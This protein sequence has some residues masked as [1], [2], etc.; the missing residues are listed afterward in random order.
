MKILLKRSLII[1]LAIFLL[2]ASSGCIET[3]AASPALIDEDAL[4]SYGWSQVEDIEYNTFEQEVSNGTSL[5]FNSTKATYQN[6]RL[7]ADIEKQT[8]EFK[9]EYMLPS[10]MQIP[11]ITAQISTNRI[12]LP[13]KLGIPTKIISKIVD[14]NVEA[15]NGQNSIGEFNESKKMQLTSNTGA[16]IY[17]SRFTAAMPLENSS[18]KMLG[19]IAIIE[20]EEYSTIVYGTTPN[21]T[22]PVKIGSLEAD[23]FSI[24]GERE[25]DE[26]IELIR[27]IE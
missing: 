21:G 12:A 4:T 20:S 14:S 11:T 9:E 26:M 19:F 22:L 2:S 15:M 10:D 13:G 3:P 8:M 16:P 5:T 23:I 6:D 18:L 25:L 1:V 17:L 7:I 24:D 27:T